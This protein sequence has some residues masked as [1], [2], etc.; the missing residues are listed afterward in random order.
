MTR[1]FKKTTYLVITLLLCYFVFNGFVIYSYSS[2]YSEDKCD[3][4]IV[5]GAGTSNGHAS[6]IFKER[7]NHSKYLYNKRI[8]KKII[9]TGG[10][11]EGQKQSDSEVGKKYLLTQGVPDNVVLIE[12]RSKYTIENLIESKHI[13]DSLGFNSALLVSDPM[14]MK[15]AIELAKQ[16]EINCKPSP[17]KTTMY[18]SFF[19]KAK[20]L[21]YETFFYSLGR[22]VGKN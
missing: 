7:I 2:N 4:A 8:I 9:I 5:L 21:V 15:R 13:M 11:G 6:S 17:T 10:Y 18:R 22:I 12:K 3:V 16:Q 1:K 14:H 20:S 19:P